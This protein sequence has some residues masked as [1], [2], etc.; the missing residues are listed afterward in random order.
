M[1]WVKHSALSLGHRSGISSILGPGTFARCRGVVKKKKKGSWS[2]QA[3]GRTG[4]GGAH[5][6][7]R[8]G[9]V[10]P[11]GRT[12]SESLQMEGADLV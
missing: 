1:Q 11:Q 4:S 12:Q 3:G 6:A 7:T 2:K 5:H 10:L 8:S 9:L